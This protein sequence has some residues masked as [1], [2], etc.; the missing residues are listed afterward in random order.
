MEIK[1]ENFDWKNHKNDMVW[2]PKNDPFLRYRCWHF[3]RSTHQSSSPR[4]SY[5]KSLQKSPYPLSRFKGF[6]GSFTCRPKNASFPRFKGPHVL[7]FGYSRKIT[8]THLIRYPFV[9][10]GSVSGIR[11]ASLSSGKNKVL[12]LTERSFNHVPENVYEE[13]GRCCQRQND[14]R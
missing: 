8:A 3:A 1:K 11:Q 13:E 12:V 14:D 2:S 10:C 6:L 7:G 4:S 9:V 5:I